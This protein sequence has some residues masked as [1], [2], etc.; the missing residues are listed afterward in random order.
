MNHIFMSLYAYRALDTSANM[1]IN[2]YGFK[3]KKSMQSRQEE[4]KNSCLVASGAI[5]SSIQDLPPMISRS[6][7]VASVLIKIPSNKILKPL[8][9]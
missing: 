5:E 6:D 9:D 8:I 3:G 1:T 4:K 2:Q 7:Q